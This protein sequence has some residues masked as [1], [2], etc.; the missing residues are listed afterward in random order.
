[1]LKIESYFVVA[2]YNPA[3]IS[4]TP[5]ALPAPVC[6]ALKRMLQAM[7]FTFLLVQ[8]SNQKGHRQT[9]RPVCRKVPD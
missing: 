3:G 4:K 7:Y 5:A 1:M 2:G 9:M 6:Y 8:K